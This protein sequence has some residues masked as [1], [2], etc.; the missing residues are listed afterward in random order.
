[1]TPSPTR[2]CPACG[3]RGAHLA[4]GHA[5]REHLRC[6]ACSTVF[7]ADSDDHAADVHAAGE[8]GHAARRRAVADARAA[9]LRKFGCRTVLEIGCG[10]GVFLDAVRDLGMQVEG[11]DPHPDAAALARGHTIHA[12]LPDAPRFD[13]VALWD[14]LAHVADPK[15]MLLQARRWLRPGGFLALSTMSS[16]G[17]PALA[18]GPRLAMVDP[19]PRTCFSRRGL[20]LSLTA[21]GFDPVRWTSASGLAREHLQHGLERVWLGASLPGRALAHGLTIAAQ[22][23][24]RA[25]DRAGL[26]SAFE[27]YAVAG[28]D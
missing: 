10:P 5:G 28:R 6:N 26:G 23:P 9:I 14:L 7:A 18:L 4:F 21:A 20:K 16:S 17:V 15:D 12:A 3:H 24:L 22:L 27:V 1:M 13:A 19:A 2:A 25:I 8:P 11:I